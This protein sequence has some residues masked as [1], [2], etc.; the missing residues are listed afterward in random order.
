MT[1]G[2]KELKWPFQ[3]ADGTGHLEKLRGMSLTH[4]HMYIYMCVCICICICIC[5]YIYVCMYACM[6]VHTYIHTYVYIYIY[7]VCVCFGNILSKLWF[8][9]LSAVPRWWFYVQLLLGETS[10]PQRLLAL[11]LEPIIW[12]LCGKA[13]AIFLAQTSQLPPVLKT[14]QPPSVHHQRAAGAAF[15]I[16]CQAQQDAP[17]QLPR[18]AL[19]KAGC[20]WSDA[21]EQPLR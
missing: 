12:D 5:I 14:S 17:R 2:I 20:T 6:H 15:H 21:G 16:I 11:A 18:E 19:R 9:I 1:L 8:N 4:T 7:C 13:E 10:W 3:P